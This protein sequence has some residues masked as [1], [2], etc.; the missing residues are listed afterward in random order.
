MVET[1]FQAF[2]AFEKQSILHY[3]FPYTTYYKKTLLKFPDSKTFSE[4]IA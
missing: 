4:L 1:T 2:E 3:F